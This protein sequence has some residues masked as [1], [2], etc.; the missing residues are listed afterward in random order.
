MPAFLMRY[1]MRKSYLRHTGMF[2]ARLR[3]LRGSAFLGCDDRSERPHYLFLNLRVALRP[4][5]PTRIERPR[6]SEHAR[7]GPIARHFPY[8]YVKQ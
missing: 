5:F 3:E 8:N 4:L 1:V 2:E 7:H 6:S